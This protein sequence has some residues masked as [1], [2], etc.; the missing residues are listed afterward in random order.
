MVSD[1]FVAVV[2]HIKPNEFRG[3][4]A[5]LEVSVLCQHIETS[6]LSR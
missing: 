5:S 3:V 2:P 4:G 6:F 1:G